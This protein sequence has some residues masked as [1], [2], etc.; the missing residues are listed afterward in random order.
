MDVL[1]SVASVSGYQAV[2][3]AS[4]L[5]PRVVPMIT[6]AGGT[7]PPATFLI[8]G[9]G[10]AGLQAIATA[11][12]LGAKVVG[13]DVRAQTKNEVESLGAKFIVVQGAVEDVN[14]GGY[15]VQQSED[16]LT[17][18]NIELEKEIVK[19]DVIITT[20][21]IPGK[22]APILIKGGIVS[23]MKPGAVIIDLA[24]SSGG[25]CELTKEGE[26][27]TANTVKIVGASNLLS[28]NSSSVSKLL[29]NNFTSFLLHMD[30]KNALNET[31][32]ILIGTKVIEDGKVVHPRLI[33]EVEN[34]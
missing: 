32:E 3:L 23:R 4:S 6:S 19:A 27:V 24:A 33:Q 31:D 10:V 26:V 15:A 34:Y 20:A 30:K 22:K 12:R 11:K 14:N 28:E 1:S 5:S 16:Y 7:L 9:A 21:R 8:I 2:L 29:G 25:N 17:R 18:L 13:F